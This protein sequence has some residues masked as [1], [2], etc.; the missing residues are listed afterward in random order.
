MITPADTSIYKTLHL[1]S[2]P[3]VRRRYMIIDEPIIGNFRFGLLLEDLDIVAE[4]TALGYVRR[5]HVDARVVTA[6][7]DNIIVRHVVDN[8]RDIMIHARINHVGR[9][10]LVVGMRVEHPGNPAIH[11]ASCYFTMVARG[12]DNAEESRTLPPLQYADE[13]EQQ[14][15][16]KA[17]AAREEYRRQQAPSKN[18]P[19]VKNSSFYSNCTMPRKSRALTD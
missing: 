15:A 14:R 6:A 12:G 19:A 11:I 13:L 1:S 7:I 9:S 8:D 5:F 10:S 17:T 18:L 3:A 2:D 4:Q 16:D